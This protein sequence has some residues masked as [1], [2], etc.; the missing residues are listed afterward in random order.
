MAFEK[1]DSQSIR[2]ELAET[3]QDPFTIAALAMEQN[4]R[5]QRR[6]RVLEQ[7]LNQRPT[8]H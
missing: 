3:G 1:T 7:L 4:Q 6:I 8:A 5:L 2:R